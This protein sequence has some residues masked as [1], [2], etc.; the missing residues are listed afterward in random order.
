MACVPHYN[1]DVTIH[2]YVCILNASHVTNVNKQTQNPLALAM[3]C[4]LIETLPVPQGKKLQLTSL[5]HGL[6]QLDM[7]VLN[8]ML[9]NALTPPLILLNWQESLKHQA[10]TLLIVLSMPGSPCTQNQ[11]KSSMTMWES[12]MLLLSNNF[13]KCEHK[14]GSDYK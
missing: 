5:G 2:I 1:P 8:F 3:V 7:V 4:F 13:Y 12:S 10:T 6:L 11:C 9:L 14:V